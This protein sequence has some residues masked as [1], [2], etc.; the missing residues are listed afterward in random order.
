MSQVSVCSTVASGRSSWRA[1]RPVLILGGFVAIWWALMTGVAHAD[2]G[3]APRHHSLDA[4]RSSAK[5]HLAPVRDAA[6]RVHHE[7]K[8][9]ST[10]ATAPVRHEVRPAI[11][12][13]TRTVTTVVSSTPV[14]EKATRTIRATVS[15]TVATT[16]KVLGDTAAGPVVDVVRGVVSDTVD[17]AES[18]TGQ[19]NSHLSRHQVSDAADTS[20]GLLA[21]TSGAGGST[22][23]D[24]ASSGNHSPSDSPSGNPTLPDPC[25]SPSGSGSSTSYTPAGVLESSLLVTPSVLRDHRSWRLARLPGGPAYE[26][27]SSPD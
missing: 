6:R 26:P 3:H 19:G 16:T 8:A 12:P 15:D 2:S 21:S 14:L 4:I 17:K 27:G 1:L 9:T 23:T 13:V 25:T 22:S 7:A 11:K 5:A 10:R 20:A 24:T 18:S